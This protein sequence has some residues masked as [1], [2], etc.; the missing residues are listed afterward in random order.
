MKDLA[1]S[2]PGFSFPPP[3]GVP[4]G[5]LFPAGQSVISLAFNFITIVSIL[6]TLAFI[7]YN[8][9]MIIISEG[10]KSKIAVARGGIAFSIIGLVLILLAAFIV[11]VI[12][13]FFGV[14]LVTP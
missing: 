5:G 1:L 7:I 14:S 13:N 12:G 8:A 6:A 9:I 4:S 11:R 3:A 2:I 10:D